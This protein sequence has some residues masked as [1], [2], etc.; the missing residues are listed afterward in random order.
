[1]RGTTAR[2]TRTLAI[3]M[4]VVIAAMATLLLSGSRGG[5]RSF[6]Q[7]V[8]K[9]IPLGGNPAGVA[10][11]P[12]TNTIYVAAGDSVSVVNG[13]TNAITATIPVSGPLALAINAATN[14]LYVATAAGI[15]VINGTTN[16]VAATVPLSSGPSSIAVNPTTNTIYVGSIGSTGSI[17]PGH[18][19]CVG[20]G[21][22]SFVGSTSSVAVISGAT[23]AVTATI[24]AS[25]GATDLAV[26][27]STNTIYAGSPYG[28][29]QCTAGCSG[30]NC[31]S[32]NSGVSVING[33]TNTLT[34]TI[35][36]PAPGGPGVLVIVAVNPTINS[37]Y[38]ATSAGGGV[39]VLNGASTSVTTNIPLSASPTSIAGEPYHQQGLC[40]QQQR[41]LG[42]RR[43]RERRHDHRGDRVWPRQHP[44]C[45]QP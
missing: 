29:W 45:G 15:S 43:R 18:A 11:N 36:E 25:D 23:N 40:C 7:A 16:S 4:A 37:V 38:S 26:N 21:F 44:R 31:V 33:A 12:S 14:R 35:P 8:T 24:P 27:P 30:G 9:T 34:D 32:Q 28:P 20:G 3:A 41:R 6:A 19:D 2:R 10:V 5:P 13:M 22:G 42:D 17:S 39:S 1:M